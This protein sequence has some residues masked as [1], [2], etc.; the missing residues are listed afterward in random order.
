[1]SPFQ[2]QGRNELEYDRSHGDGLGIC[3]SLDKRPG[4]RVNHTAEYCNRM[5]TKKE[6]DDG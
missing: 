3:V 4:T 2:E 6:N 1:M 5:R